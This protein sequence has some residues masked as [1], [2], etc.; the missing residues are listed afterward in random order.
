MS[1]CGA[2]PARTSPR[3]RNLRVDTTRANPAPSPN[4]RRVLVLSPARTPP[5]RYARSRSPR[6]P[7]GAM[8]RFAS[9]WCTKMCPHARCSDRACTFAHR[10]CELRCMFFWGHLGCRNARSCRFRHE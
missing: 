8:S 6:A 3:R 1:A 7:G 4:A 2:E 10:R 5:P 9:T